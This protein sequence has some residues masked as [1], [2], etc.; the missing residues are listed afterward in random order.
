MCTDLSKISDRDLILRIANIENLKVV[1][2]DGGVVM[3]E[4]FEGNTIEYNPITDNA[5]AHTLQ[6]KYRVSVD[7]ILSRC[8]IDS[9]LESYNSGVAY[10]R[11]GCCPNRAIL[12]AI[13]DAKDEYL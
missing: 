6:C 5:L 8:Y 12:E 4:P 9:K 1:Y 11:V 13:Y 2:T 3:V 7:F 10:F